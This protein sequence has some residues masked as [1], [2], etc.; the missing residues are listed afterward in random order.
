MFTVLESSKMS[1]YDQNT[2]S[3][4]ISHHAAPPNSPAAAVPSLALDHL[5]IGEAS[6]RGE[7]PLQSLM[8]VGISGCTSS[9]KSLLASLL[10]EVFD[11]CKLL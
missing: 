7:K 1:S 4:P 5:E 3:P 8:V 9:G 6:S 11:K 10:V 2:V